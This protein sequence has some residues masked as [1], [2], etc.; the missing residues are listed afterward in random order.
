MIRPLSHGAACQM[1]ESPKIRV[2]DW[3][4]TPA[5]N[6]LERG[7]ESIRIKPRSM[8]VLVY[9]ATHAGKVVST[10]ELIHAVWQGRIV[11]DGTVYQSITNLRQ[12]FR[13]SAEDS[14][15]IET[16]PKRGYR[17]LA[18]VG[19]PGEPGAEEGADKE[20]WIVPLQSRA[21]TLTVGGVL[22]GLVA[23]ALAVVI[24]YFYP[25]KREPEGTQGVRRFAID[26]GPTQGLWETGLSAHV[27]I[28]PDARYLAYVTRIGDASRL[29]LRALNQLE[30]TSIAEIDGAY[31][32]F[33]SPDGEWLAFFDDIT[34]GNLKKISV[35]G[36]SPEIITNAWAAGGGSWHSE[37]TIVLSTRH[38]PAMPWRSLIAVSPLGGSPN[39]LLESS[40]AIVYQWPYVLPGGDFVLFTRRVAGV[41]A[42]EA[43][44]ALL[45]L[46]TG[47]YRT[48]LEGA[49]H[50]QYASS[51][52]IV[53][54]R[55]SGIWAV[56]FDI[57]RMETT[58][59]ETV[60]LEGVQVDRSYGAVTYSFSDDGTL[61]Y[62]PEIDRNGTESSRSRLAWV[63]R[64]GSEELLQDGHD[65][66]YTDRPRISPDGLRVALEVIA[67]GNIDIW[68]YDI[69]QETSSRLTFDPRIDEVPL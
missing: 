38:V 46:D 3:S 47:E 51:G 28:S 27:A 26:V 68:I 52:H 15:I 19:F 10:E 30:P 36:G 45:S 61:V 37:D 44:I 41:P 58:G 33:F 7:N 13:D 42:T 1:G 14:R 49:Y 64:G 22:T 35:H 50:G 16:I 32:P 55:G 5:R 23:L 29:N 2:A 59:P 8:E 18:D 54:A 21:V 40:S 6:L 62:A 12:A 63:D 65:G 53:F 60:V 17:L 4:V 66:S 39:L 43:S 24:S 48:V 20:N 67:A 9:L 57:D 34:E 11:S 56:P 25:F 69:V 31:Y